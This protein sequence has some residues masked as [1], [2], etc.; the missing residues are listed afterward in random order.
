MK[1]LQF[2]GQD[3]LLIVQAPEEFENSLALFRERTNVD[4]VPKKSEQY[5]FML[6]F[7]K[8][9]SDVASIQ[10]VV[11]NQLIKDG[12]LWFAYPKKTSERYHRFLVI[13]DGREFR[14]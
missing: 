13:K 12:L 9:P 8:A 3:N 5:D 6:I 11:K 10:M 1:K 7:V 14:I 4:E 2:K